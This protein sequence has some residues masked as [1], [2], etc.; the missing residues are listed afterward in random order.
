MRVFGKQ[1]SGVV[2]RNLGSTLRVSIRLRS[3]YDGFLAS[4]EAITW[5]LR[6][7]SKVVFFKEVTAVVV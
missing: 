5:V 4:W 6:P 2:W 1:H 7:D 3:E